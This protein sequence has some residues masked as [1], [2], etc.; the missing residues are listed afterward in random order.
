MYSMYL[1]KLSDKRLSWTTQSP[2]TV[3]RWKKKKFFFFQKWKKSFREK[4]ESVQRR[5]ESVLILA[6]LVALSRGRR[7]KMLASRADVGRPQDKW[8]VMYIKWMTLCKTEKTDLFASRYEY[9]WEAL[10]RSSPRNRL[11]SPF[12]RIGSKRNCRHK[13]LSDRGFLAPLTHPQPLCHSPLLPSLT[14]SFLSGRSND[15][16]AG[17]MSC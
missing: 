10:S 5:T 12:Y 15:V 8:L 1:V 6:K 13:F 2:K 14:P 16:C 3:R 7:R 11:V 17:G 4:N 9:L